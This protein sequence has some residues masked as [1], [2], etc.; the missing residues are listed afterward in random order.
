MPVAAAG[1]WTRG[2]RKSGDE[3]AFEVL[4]HFSATVRGFYTSIAKAIH[5]PSRRREEL[6]ATATPVMRVAAA[7]LAVVL[8]KNLQLP[9]GR[10][11]VAFMVRPLL[12]PIIVGHLSN[13]DLPG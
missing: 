13:P 11:E 4:Q 9:S 7:N 10:R 1:L 8:V 12:H 2:K 5:S 3:L 6:P